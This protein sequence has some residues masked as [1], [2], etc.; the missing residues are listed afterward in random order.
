MKLYTRINFKCS[1]LY[2]LARASTPQRENKSSERWYKIEK[3]KS[4]IFYISGMHTEARL[5]NG[6]TI[7]Q[8]SSPHTHTSREWCEKRIKNFLFCSLSLNSTFFLLARRVLVSAVER[9][10]WKTRWISVMEQHMC[11]YICNFLTHFSSS[12]LHDVSG[13]S[14]FPSRLHLCYAVQEAA[15]AAKK[16]SNV[17]GRDMRWY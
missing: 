16:W 8:K 17:Q 3:K 14:I 10:S 11:V 4:L 2:S 1:T 9:Q 5:E 15:K 12:P 6:K 13:I 7:S